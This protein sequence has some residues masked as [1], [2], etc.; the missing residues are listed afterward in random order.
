MSLQK[1]LSILF[2]TIVVIPLLVVGFLSYQ[3][4]KNS[5]IVQVTD[6]LIAVS[7]IQEKR[8]NEALERY[9]EKVQAIT[10][11]TQLRASIK[12]Y[13]ETGD[14]DAIVTI[15]K[16]IQD[17][18][19]ATPSIKKVSVLDTHGLVL[20]STDVA[21]VGKQFGSEEYFK[22]GLKTNNFSDVF[23][24]EQNILAVR[25]SGP[26]VLDS[27]MVGVAIIDASA[28]SLVTI[29]E[30]YTGLGKTGE[31]VLA[32]RNQAGDALFLTPL[33]FDAGAALR[34]AIPKEETSSPIISALYGNEDAF[35]G[36]DTK[37]YRDE[38]VFASTRF[39]EALGW[40]MVVKIDQ[41]EVFAP[42]NNLLTTFLLLV[43]SVALLSI[44]VA[45]VAGR[46]IFRPISELTITAGNFQK[47]DFSKRVSVQSKDEIGTLGTA[48]NT[49]AEK[50]QGLYAGLEQKVKER[51]FEL[52]EA[53][54]KVEAILANIGDGFVF[55]DT[56]R[57][58][59]LVN[60]AS[61]D[62]LGYK[63]QELL[64]KLW[65]DIVRPKEDNGEELSPDR[66][67][68]NKLMSS[69][70]TTTTT[71]T[72]DSY[73][74]TKKDGTI[75]PVAVTASKVSIK[76]EVIGAIII[77]RD[78]TKD[79]Q[80][81]R[82]KTEFV[83]L[84]SHQL[85]TPLAIVSWYSE[86]LLNGDAGKVTS[87][88]KEYLDEVYKGNKR[89]TV[90]VDA[91]LNVSRLELGM[92]IS[93]PE[94]TDMVA[95]VKDVIE[96]QKVVITSK[97]LQFKEL[98]E[99]DLP[100]IHVDPKLMHMVFQ[101]LVSNAVKYTPDGGGVQVAIKK[102]KGGLVITVSDTGY[103]IPKSQQDRIFTKLFRADNVREKDTQGTGIGLYIVKS[104]IDHEGGTIRFESE[105]NKGTA[106]YVT[107]PIEGIKKKSPAKD[108]T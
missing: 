14:A 102:E 70:T 21:L 108:I 76:G 17:A 89:M 71:T 87:K 68:I 28:D 57:R 7:S 35:L 99:P 46:I 26:F 10:S 95:L 90:L 44:V 22:K 29:T 8:V 47:G 42:I 84:A 80:I 2:V 49:M 36:G 100:K 13:T 16:I 9:L 40:G 85:L 12:K 37:D 65:V 63:E 75:F 94:P 55:I 48:F 60:R 73:N 3:T 105:E 50:L 45:L 38:L 64:G 79:K 93:E 72:T 97:K 61:E 43:L 92:F 18:R 77:F 31:V 86:M 25:L 101:N 4:L 67:M 103:G 83:S 91:L 39:I 19:I 27:K 98:Y 41:A 62:I 53:K 74:Y 32:E 78:I 54:V 34:R 23:K 20:A 51:T 5:S 106:F 6:Q 81:D 15:Q 107:L 11:R 104:T 69:T 88:Q 1:K 30:D 82:A 33:R 96:E 56:K 66:F 52:E 58:V 59:L 24:D